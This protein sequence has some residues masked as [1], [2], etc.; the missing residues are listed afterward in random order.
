M[1]QKHDVGFGSFNMCT[2]QQCFFVGRKGNAAF[3]AEEF[4]FTDV[5]F[6]CIHIFDDHCESFYVRWIAEEP[7][8]SFGK[9]TFLQASSRSMSNAEMRSICV[10][11]LLFVSVTS[12]WDSLIVFSKEKNSGKEIFR[13]NTPFDSIHATM[14]K[15]LWDF[16]FDC[17]F[18]AGWHAATRTQLELRMRN[19]FIQQ[20]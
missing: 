11:F 13:P 3:F 20:S 16:V 14:L 6:L 19:F 8:S 18:A 1:R 5:R 7:G 10:R 4:E 9:F 2:W 17:M 15:V 12:C